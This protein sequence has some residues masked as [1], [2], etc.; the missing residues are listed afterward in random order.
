MI[1]QLKNFGEFFA[2]P[3]CKTVYNQL[4]R[5]LVRKRQLRHPMLMPVFQDPSNQ[6]LLAKLKELGSIN[7]WGDNN[8]VGAHSMQ[9][10]VSMLQHLTNPGRFVK[11]YAKAARARLGWSGVEAQLFI[12]MACGYDINAKSS[13]LQAVNLDKEHVADLKEEAAKHHRLLGMKN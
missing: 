11:L 4:Q 9:L 10:A 3:N 12:R 8:T 13:E 6:A 1:R 2:N 5:L 7:M